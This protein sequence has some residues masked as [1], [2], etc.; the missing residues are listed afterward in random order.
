[1]YN[2][3]T[4]CFHSSILVDL[5]KEQHP[6]NIKPLNIKNMIYKVKEKKIILKNES[7]SDQSYKIGPICAAILSRALAMD[8]G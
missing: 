6:L 4:V 5:C 2:N 1:M 7:L 8:V 3:Y